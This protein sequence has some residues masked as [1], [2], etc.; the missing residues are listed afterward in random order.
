[1]TIR[2]VFCWLLATALIALGFVKRATQRAMK[3]EFI[4]AVYFHNPSRRE[5]ETCIKWLLKHKFNIISAADV[6]NL[7]HNKLP[8]PKG[9]VV[10]T[11]DDGWKCNEANIAEVANQY[12]VPVTIFVSTEPV[13]KGTY[14]WSY[15][16]EAK[17][18][19]LRV[20]ELS[21]VKGLANEERLSIL[22]KLKKKVA[23]QREAMTVEQIKRIS[24]SPYITIGGHTHTH[25]I[26]PNCKNKQ[27]YYE[28]KHSKKKLAGWLG[29]DIEFFAY[30]N[31]DFS[32]RE[33]RM[34]HD[35]N[36]K[37]AFN[38]EQTYLTPAMLEHAYELPR[39]S[40]LEGASLAENI[41]RITGIWKPFINGFRKPFFKKHRQP[42]PIP[43]FEKEV[44]YQ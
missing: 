13:E 5:F 22:H 17:K 23:L 4:L 30:P 16:I 39:F 11:A 8:F 41:C 2:N 26:L 20:P 6:A 24:Q 12:K 40:Y 18:R 38:S 43:T 10:L 7:V 14:W 15:L 33:V 37:I 36:Y 19:K 34:L 31:G 29:K 27:A 42:A 25:P 21:A 35:L 1:M 28:L 32:K 44:V 9:A 3:G